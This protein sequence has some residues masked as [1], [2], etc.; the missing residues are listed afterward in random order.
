MEFHIATWKKRIQTVLF[1]RMQRKNM[2]YGK[3]K[4]MFKL[5]SFRSAGGTMGKTETDYNFSAGFIQDLRALAKLV[6]LTEDPD[7]VAEITISNDSLDIIAE[8][9]FRFKENG[10]I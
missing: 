2:L 10:K 9:R 1:A 8:I 6:V 4:M 3:W 7:S 5:R